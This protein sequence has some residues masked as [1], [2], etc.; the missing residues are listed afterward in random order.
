MLILIALIQV[1]ANFCNIQIAALAGNIIEALGLTTAQFGA[2]S[3]CSFLG[4][5]FVGIICGG[6]GDRYGIKRVI[7]IVG[8][9]S[10]AG[11]IFRIYS[12]SFATLFASMFILGLVMAALNANSSKIVAMWFH[13]RQMGFAMSVYIATSTVGAVL[14]LSST[15]ILLENGFSIKSIYIV[16]LVFLVVVMILWI[17]LAKVKPEGAADV[18]SEPV[19][20]YIGNVIGD[21]HL[22]INSIAMFC[23]MGAFISCSTYMV[24][25]VITYKGFS[26]LEAGSLSTISAIVAVPL[27]LIIPSI[28][29]KIGY[30]RGGI[31]TIL[32]LGAALVSIGW[33]I[34]DFG[35][36]QMA[37]F[38]VGISLIGNGIPL[39]KQYPA[40]L[41]TIKKDSIGSAGGIQSTMQNL[42]GFLVPSYI[43]GT[44]VGDNINIVFYGVAITAVVAAFLMLFVPE[45][46][47]K[48]KLANNGAEAKKAEGE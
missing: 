10:V 43:L 25:G 11:A 45:V 38:V 23:I 42:G 30:I 4:G 14:A 15:P 27:M 6:L 44:I 3:S 33:G 26:P 35:F 2:V 36:L 12:T 46:G 5:A 29:V 9:I 22:W 20:K 7:S 1:A 18:K 19:L 24:V 32:I 40:M 13:P 31:V 39:M 47:T 41:P 17:I 28:I 34:G 8:I 37:L 48:G 21:K 16:G